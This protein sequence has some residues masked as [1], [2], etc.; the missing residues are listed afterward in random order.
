MVGELLDLPR[1]GAPAVSESQLNLRQVDVLTHHAGVLAGLALRFAAEDLPVDALAMRA[2][3]RT[4]REAFPFLA[5]AI[6][7]SGVLEGDET[8]TD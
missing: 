2:M 8:P 5:D 1:L 3:L 7:R 4:L 6:A